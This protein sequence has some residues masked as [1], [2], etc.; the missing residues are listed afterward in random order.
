MVMC[1]RNNV[2]RIVT[3]ADAFD[4]FGRCRIERVAP[5]GE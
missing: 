1:E 5:V 3:A 4:G 2:R